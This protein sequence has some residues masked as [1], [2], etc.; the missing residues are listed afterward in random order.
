MDSLARMLSLMTSLSACSAVTIDASCNPARLVIA[1]N[2]SKNGEQEKIAN[3]LLAKINHIKLAIQ[4]INAQMTTAIKIIPHEQKHEQETKFTEQ[5]AIDLVK[6]LLTEQQCSLPGT[7]ILQAAT[8]F[9]HAMCFDQETFSN[10]EKTALLLDAPAV[11]ILPAISNSQTH[12]LEMQIRDNIPY[13]AQVNIGLINAGKV[14][15]KYIHAEQ[16][17]VEYLRHN[18]ADMKKNFFSLGIAKLCCKTCT[19]Y[20]KNFTNINKRGEHGQSYNGVVNLGDG[21]ITQINCTKTAITFAHN[22]PSHTPW[23]S[24][25]AQGKHKS[26]ASSANDAGQI[27]AGPELEYSLN[28]PACARQL[29]FNS[30]PGLK[31]QDNNQEPEPGNILSID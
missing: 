3:A 4:K 23:A 11:I 6:K 20:L 21:S 10:K 26:Q 7:L 17:L 16:L 27:L 18:V 12:H 8:K 14:S 9:I 30:S 15:V 13:Q 22:S 29:F 5:Y 19:E 25:K 28:N 31:P 24:F 1:A 2:V